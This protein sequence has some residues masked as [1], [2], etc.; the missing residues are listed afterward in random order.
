MTTRLLHGV[1]AEIRAAHQSYQS[2]VKEN[3]SQINLLKSLLDGVFPEFTTVFKD[4]RGKTALA[5]LCTYAIPRNIVQLEFTAFLNRV[6]SQF[7]G[8]APK[9]RML[10][11]LY[12]CAG[13]SIGIPEGAEA[14]ALEIRHLVQRIK[15]NLQQ[16]A[17]MVKQLRR[18]VDSLPES[19]YMLSIPGLGY[20]TVAG[21]IAG[22]GRI[23][24]YRNGGQLIKMAGTNP[25]Q[26]E[27]AGKASSHTP[28]SK[29]GR[30]GL[31]WGLWP[32]WS[33]C[34]AII[35]TL[36][37]GQKPGRNGRCS[38]SPAPSGSDRSGS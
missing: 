26:K 35:Q 9:T 21:L 20:L 16:K 36:K 24:D 18:L 7:V 15:L 28:M 12:Q 37:P 32:A 29:Q 25:T 8:R 5:V 4:L 27:S 13:E 22:L 14:V 11:E 6:R 2:L 31:R 1:Y 3:T 30:A 34:Y 19:A 23:E 10:R 17:L 38:P 33:P